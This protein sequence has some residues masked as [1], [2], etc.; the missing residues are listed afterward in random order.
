MAAKKIQSKCIQTFLSS[1]GQVL[2][3][4][5]CL[6]V[7]NDFFNSKEEEYTKAKKNYFVKIKNKIFYQ[8]SSSNFSDIKRELVLI[9]LYII[10]FKKEALQ[11]KRQFLVENHL[12][13]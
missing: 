11:R 1:E 3:Y 2:S 4:R 12:N 6:Q 9:Q 5:T 7:S 10:D 13:F 8:Y